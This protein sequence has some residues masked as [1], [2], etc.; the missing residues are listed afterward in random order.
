MLNLTW[1]SLPMLGTIK[2]SLGLFLIPRTKPNFKQET[3]K[4]LKSHT[5]GLNNLLPGQLWIRSF[6]WSEV[7]AL[8]LSNW[9]SSWWPTK[10]HFPSRACFYLA[11]LAHFLFLTLKWSSSWY[12]RG[13]VW[14]PLHCTLISECLCLAEFP[15]VTHDLPPKCLPE[16]PFTLSGVGKSSC[17]S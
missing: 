12:L 17:G 3:T 4:K 13:E 1:C 9:R 15:T 6:V 16:I 2:S 8:F 7:S 10:Y 14:L 11:Y 5:L